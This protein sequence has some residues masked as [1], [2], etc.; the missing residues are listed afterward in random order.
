MAQAAEY[1]LDVELREDHW[2]ITSISDRPGTAQFG[3]AVD[4]GTT[5]VAVLLVDLS[6]GAVVSQAAAFNQQMHL[7]D[8]VVTRITLCCNDP[9]MVSQLQQAVAA[10]TIAPLIVQAL[11]SAAISPQQVR[12]M[13]LAGNTTML[14]LVAGVN[15]AS[16]GTSPFTPVFLAHRIMPASQIF[17]DHCAG[18]C[19]EQAPV[20][21]L[22]GP[23]AYVGADLSAGVI[24]SGLLYDEGPSLLVDVGTNGEIIL[25]YNGKLYGCATAAGPAF[26]GAGLS[27]GIRAGDGAISHIQLRRAPFS[28]STE[29]IGNSKNGH[30]TGLCGSAYVDFLAEARRI[31]LLMATGRFDREAIFDPDKHLLPWGDHD[32]ALRIALGQGRRDIVVS[33]LDISRLLQ[34][35]AAIAAGILTLLDRVGVRAEQIKTV[36]LAG[37]FGTHMS[38]AAAINCGLLPG[39]APGQIQPVGNSSLA[40]AIWHCSTAASSTSFPMLAGTSRW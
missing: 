37:G 15:P 11:A 33:Q 1:H 5:T 30:P 19:R 18:I 3:V 36:Y 17:G 29:W 40:G 26:E 23:A 10:R 8:D 28:I 7:G 22:P 31:G 14:H 38:A 9:A 4:I 32:T 20:H 27:C 6:D 13:T 35:K 2:L 24:A 25:K 16:M 39:F 12:C 21:L 34:A